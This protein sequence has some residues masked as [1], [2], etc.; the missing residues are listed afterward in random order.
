[1]EERLKLM[2]DNTAK[3][4]DATYYRLFVGSLRYLAHTRPDLALSVS[5]VSRCMQRPTKDHEQDVK[6]ILRYVAGSLDYALFHPRSPGAARF[7][8]YVSTLMLPL[9]L[10]RHFG[11]LGCSVTS[12][13]KRL[14]LLISGWTTSLLLHRQRIQSSMITTS[15]FE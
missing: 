11:L 7:I 15:T 3:E 1:M 12:L 14:K 4:V 5:Y 8:S 13:A 6:R 2:H 10:L 9:L